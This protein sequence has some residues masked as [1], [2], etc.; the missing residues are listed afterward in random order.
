ME[1]KL[2]YEFKDKALL[3]KA[4]THPSYASENSTKSYERL[5]FLG[6]S[7]LGL[8]IS[9]LLFEKFPDEQEGE[10]ARRRS[11]LVC[12]STLSKVAKTF[13]LGMDILMG[14]GEEANGGRD[15]DANLENTL[16]AIIGAIYL[17]G[18]LDP[19]KKYVLS[20]FS[21]LTH[22]MT[23]PP[24]D[25]KTSLQEWAQGRGL[26]LPEYIT[27]CIEG[28][29]HAPDFTVEVTVEDN[30]V[31]IGNGSSKKRAEREAARHLF[32]QISTGEEE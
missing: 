20:H 9:E 12:G 24:K 25:A 21:E 3:T 8:I 4:L 10:L 15:N 5:E 19:A 17:D 13:N 32:E 28:P 22:S 31:G 2:D 26:P 16:E 29:S 27:V 1:D 14:T 11:A 6:D 23:E 18:G 30:G 7:V